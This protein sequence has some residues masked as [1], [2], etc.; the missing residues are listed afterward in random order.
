MD[1]GGRVDQGAVVR[2]N[3]AEAGHGKERP[4]AGGP[5]LLARVLL[6]RLG[7]AGRRE[8]I[9]A[10]LLE[11][12]RRRVAASGRLYAWRRYWFDVISL[13]MRHGDRRAPVADVVKDR[14]GMAT[15]LAFDARQA[16]RAVRRMPSFFAIAAVTLAVGFSAH[17]AAFTVVDRLLLASPPHVSDP[18]SLRRAA[19][20][21]RRH[22]R[23]TFPLV[24]EPVR[25]LPGPAHASRS[26]DSARGL[27]ALSHQ[28]GCR[29]RRAEVS[30]AF[31]DGDYFRILGA[32]AA[33]GRVLT[34]EDDPAPS[35]RR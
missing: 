16:L 26:I 1:R 6:R 29:S 23:W 10:D 34:P 5:P 31:A 27:S 30:V 33:I 12:F 7:R 13:A 11:L 18:D 21:T 35:G 24:P 4:G 19:H 3:P 28:P 20:R 8:E 32:S 17:F 9:E 25:G 14:A 2:R 22:S 15:A